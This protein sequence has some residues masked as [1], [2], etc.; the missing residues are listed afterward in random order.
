MNRSFIK[1]MGAIALAMVF[2]LFLAP[3]SAGALT[4]VEVAKLVAS[5]GASDDYFGYSVAVDGDTAVIGAYG[6]RDYGTNS[7]SAYVFSRIDG[8]WM[9]QAKLTA[10]DGAAYDY[11][12]ISVAVDGDTAVIGAHND[13]DNG[14]SSGS[15]YVFS[16]I[17]GTWEQQAKLKAPNWAAG[18]L[19]GYS[20][21]VDGDTAVIGAYGDYYYGTNSGAAYVF[22]RSGSTWEQQ[23]K[24]TAPGG[25][26]N[27]YFGLSVAVDGDTAVIGAFGD[28]NYF[29]S[30][31]AYVFSRSGGIWLQQAKLTASDEAA[32]DYFGYS[33]AVDGSTAVIGAL[34]DDDNDFSNSGAAYVFSR[35][36]GTWA[37]QAKLTAPDGASS[38][39]FGCSVAVDGDTAAVIGVRYDDDKGTSS[40]SAYVFS[41]APPDNDQDGV[42]DDQDN[43]P[44][45][46]NPDQADTDYDTLG[47]A[48]DVTFNAE[49]VIDV[50][51]FECSSS[52]ELLTA[53]DPPGVKGMISKLTGNGG[54]AAKVAKAK[55]DYAKGKIEYHTY[56]DRLNAALN[57]LDAYDTQLEDKTDRGKIADTYALKL[58]QKSADMRKGIIEVIRHVMP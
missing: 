32:N 25:A 29:N 33:V 40:G 2:F 6:D 45:T 16:R 44:D 55:N 42:P 28:G 23:A 35:S 49:A 17:S 14:P 46:P 53:A 21:A 56:I 36:G 57:Q 41:L 4:P 10:S 1:K 30:G 20:V 58:E 12:G 15:A 26:A 31:A 18:S 13:E 38:D 7:G 22:S 39:S 27:Q 11:F 24:I 3:F 19:F 9:Q 47:D 54:V 50:L 48:C 5:D 51:E 8:T 52:I 37:Q 43:C 34:Y